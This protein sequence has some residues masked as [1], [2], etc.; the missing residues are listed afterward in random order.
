MPPIHFIEMSIDIRFPIDI[1]LFTLSSKSYF[2]VINT[3]VRKYIRFLFVS[4]NG[5]LKSQLQLPIAFLIK[6]PEFTSIITVLDLKLKLSST[7]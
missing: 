5:A 7:G 1:G 4:K 2:I 3:K 6:M